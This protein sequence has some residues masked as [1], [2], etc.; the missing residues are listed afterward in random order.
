MRKEKDMAALIEGFMC[1][2]E[3][4]LDVLTELLID[5][6]FESCTVAELIQWGDGVVEWDELSALGLNYQ[7]PRDAVI[8][9][10][11]VLQVCCILQEAIS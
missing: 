2:G 7:T 1:T 9:R 3:D 4:V 6:D 5:E 8:T 10:Q 11:D